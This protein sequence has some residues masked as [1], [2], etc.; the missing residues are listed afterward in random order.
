[1]LFYKGLGVG[2]MSD[3]IS[4]G[5]FKMSYKMEIRIDE[6]VKNVVYDIVFWA[7][8]GIIFTKD[9]DQ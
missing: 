9:L 7:A 1:M 5:G 4:K 8:F 6:S 3:N 2:Q